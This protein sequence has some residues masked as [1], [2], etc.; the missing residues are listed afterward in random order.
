MLE[1]LNSY[2]LLN[3]DKSM[4]SFNIDLIKFSIGFSIHDVNN[5]AGVG[6]PFIECVGAK[7]IQIEVRS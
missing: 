6:C 7:F 5:R 1:L 2:I 4:I 3:I